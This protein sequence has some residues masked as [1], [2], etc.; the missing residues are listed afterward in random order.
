MTPDIHKSGL[1]TKPSAVTRWSLILTSCLLLAIWPL[2]GTIA[3]RHFLLIAAAISSL[4][5]LTSYRSD[6]Q[7]KILAPLLP[8]IAFFAW[9]L[10]HFLFFSSNRE[11][12]LDELTGLWFRSLLSAIAG[13]GFG[14]MALRSMRGDF[15]RKAFEIALLLGLSGTLIIYLLRY[16]YEIAVTGGLL[17]ENFFMTPFK[18]KPQIVVFVTIFIAALY[19]FVASEMSRATSRWWIVISGVSL[20]LFVFYTANTKNGFLI[21]LILT[22]LFLVSILIKGRVKKSNLIWISMIIIPI[23]FFAHKHI[24]SEPAWRNMI[25]DVKV[26]LDIDSQTYWKNW[27]DEPLPVNELGSPVNQSTYLRTAWATAAV[28]LIHETPL[29]YGLMSY[30]FTFLAQQKWPDFDTKAGLFNVATHSGW[31]DLTL[32]L[33]LPATALILFSLGKS[34]LLSRGKKDFLNAFA[35]WGIISLVPM[36]MTVEV[37][38]DVFFELL[39]FGAAFFSIITAN[40]DTPSISPRK[41]GMPC[42]QAI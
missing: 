31:I 40:T 11:A 41:P 4:H 36:Y 2:P 19:A 1:L 22:G 28:K 35:F 24:S 29:G 26:G 16:G 37:S 18:G 3:L 21:F 15:S 8:L 27:K 13:S 17:H 30:S 42:E 33:G 25:A 20:S 38:F 6:P 7:P 12:Q 14:L 34:F 23:V 32:A 5:L 39:L 9:I 10:I